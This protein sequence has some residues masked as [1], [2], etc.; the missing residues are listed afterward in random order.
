M[1][2]CRVICQ[3]PVIATETGYHNSPNHT[4][5]LRMPGIS[6]ASTCKYFVR[7]LPEYYLRGVVRTYLYELLD[8]R[9]KPLDA[10]SNVGILRADGTPKPAYT[11]V[12]NLN[13]LLSDPG[14]PFKPGALRWTVSDHEKCCTF[15]TTSAILAKRFV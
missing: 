12:K 9:R 14:P 5:G 4:D 8:L 1:E 10:E 15:G 11:S 13:A 3:R 6:E 7:L 2:R